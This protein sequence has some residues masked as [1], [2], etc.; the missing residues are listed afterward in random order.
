MTYRNGAYVVDTREGRLAQV[1]GEKGGRVQVRRPGG[2][3]T[4]EAPASALR[5]ATREELGAAGLL[6]Y[7]SDCGECVELD[8]IRQAAGIQDRPR[9]TAATWTHW[10]AAHSAANGH[11]LDGTAV[12]AE[13]PRASDDHVNEWSAA[14]IS[15][16][17]ARTV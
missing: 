9:A 15:D 17:S 6:P 11:R 8:A 3:L 7:R 5:L 4:W 10:I 13:A 16:G 2:E 12:V 14:T 1:V